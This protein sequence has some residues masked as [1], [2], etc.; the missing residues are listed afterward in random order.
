MK[1]FL[2]TLSR[3]RE[4]P[5]F[6]MIVQVELALKNNPLNGPTPAAT[7]DPLEDT[8]TDTRKNACTASA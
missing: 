4:L 5:L 1:V 6:P 3:G 2:G 8:D 7:A